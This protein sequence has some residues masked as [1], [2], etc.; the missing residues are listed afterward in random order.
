MIKNIWIKIQYHQVKWTA[1][2]R[3]LGRKN[4][5]VWVRQEKLVKIGLIG[6]GISMGYKK[7]QNL[8]V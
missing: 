3:R 8:K 7:V 1:E 2:G 4:S 5:Q 6:F